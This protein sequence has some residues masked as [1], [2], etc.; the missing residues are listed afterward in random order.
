MSI[1]GRLN[2]NPSKSSWRVVAGVGSGWR[3]TLYVWTG[4]RQQQRVC[5]VG[6]VHRWSMWV[7]PQSDGCQLVR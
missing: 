3:V 6:V 4:V 7:C 5:K 2:R 1:A